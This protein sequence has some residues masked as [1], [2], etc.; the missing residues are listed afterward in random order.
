MVKEKKKS[1]DKWNGVQLYLIK[2]SLARLKEDNFWEVY[3]CQ[4]IQFLQV[5]TS[6]CDSVNHLDGWAAKFIGHK[7]F[8]FYYLKEN[9]SILFSLV[10]GF[11]IF[12]Q[13]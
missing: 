6:L 2:Q 13:L 4:S 9:Y 11:D 7:V 8:E 5:L 12:K 1:D 3:I 10:S